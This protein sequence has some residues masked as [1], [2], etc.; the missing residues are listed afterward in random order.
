MH[1]QTQ[2]VSTQ[3]A[4]VKNVVGW[5]SIH[6]RLEPLDDVLDLAITVRWYAGLFWS[7]FARRRSNRI[8]LGY[9]RSPAPT[10]L[11]HPLV[12]MPFLFQT[13]CKVTLQ[14]ICV[15]VRTVCFWYRS[16]I[17]HNGH[18]SHRSDYG[19]LLIRR[20]YKKTTVHFHHNLILLLNTRYLTFL[21]WLIKMVLVITIFIVCIFT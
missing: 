7:W 18:R 5:K 4:R 11:N 10:K 14:A 21:P 16:Y 9:L 19:K 15:E 1:G 12:I 13:T 8:T 2:R 17:I 20:F 3:V 6:A